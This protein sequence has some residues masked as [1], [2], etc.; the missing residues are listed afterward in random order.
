M[1]LSFCSAG[2]A[3]Y[4]RKWIEQDKAMAKYM[5]EEKKARVPLMINVEKIQLAYRDTEKIRKFFALK[6]RYL[7]AAGFTEEDFRP[8]E[9]VSHERGNNL[10]LSL[11]PNLASYAKKMAKD[12]GSTHQYVLPPRS[13]EAEG[14]E[15]SNAVAITQDLEVIVEVVSS[16]DPYEV[17]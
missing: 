13:K 1:K 11:S 4:E 2:D 5:I 10:C 9:L 6:A 7:P 12:M 17:G 16:Q 15:V 14:A 3:E 8:G